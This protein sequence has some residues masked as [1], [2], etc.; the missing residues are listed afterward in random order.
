MSEDERLR[1]IEQ[2]LETLERLVRQL[3]AEKGSGFRVQS[4]ELEAHP[5]SVPESSRVPREPVPPP[6]RPAPGRLGTRNSEPGTS[7]ISEE[8]LGTRGLLAVGVVF[9]V[10]GAGYLLKLSFDRGWISPLVRCTGGALAGFGLGA[11]GW[12][13]HGKGYRTY[14]AAIIGAGGAIMYLAAWAAGR[15]YQFLP[16]T[17][18]IASLALISLALAAVAWAIDIQALASAAA[19]GAFFAPIVIGKEA[20]SVDLLL[21]YLGAMGACL[22]AVAWARRWRLTAFVV[23]LAYFG[24]V[25]AGVLSRAHPAGLYLYAILG[26]SAGLY[27]GLTHGWLETRFLAFWGGWGVLAVA[28]SAAHTHW[29]T[30]VGGAVLAAPVWWRALRDH[31]VLPDLLADGRIGIGDTFY[32]YLTPILFGWALSTVIHGDLARHDGLVPA[33]VALPY[34]AAGVSAPRRPFA[35]VAAG[36]LAFGALVEW[37]NLNAVWVLFGLAHL[38]ALLDHAASRSDGRWYAILT[39]AAGFAQLMYLEDRR[40][41]GDEAFTGPWALALW[42]A[43]EVLFAFAAGLVRRQADEPSRWLRPLLWGAGGLVLFFGVTGEL[44]RAF[45][46]Q[47][48][49]GGLSVSAWWILFAAG[50]FVLGFLR[51][52]KP[53]RYAGFVVAALALG[54]VLLVDLSTLDAFYRIGSVLILGIVSLGVAYTYHRRAGR[55]EQA[56]GGA[57]T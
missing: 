7:L 5:P 32:F 17:P 43:V 49:A 1:R 48:L 45:E 36:A 50:C 46:G 56:R 6:P 21:L 28:N 4:S 2:R 37:Q 25:L 9:L 14:G 51:A 8:W 44:R 31:A 55:A 57:R 42:L 16:A 47:E 11:L 29:A 52:Q 39:F 41:V 19:L 23:A 13:I 54:K 3:T 53:L 40:P 30:A 27:L 20:G 24:I 18:A 34:L 15:L 38:W 22:G 35:L 10:L 26:G 33:L 12:R